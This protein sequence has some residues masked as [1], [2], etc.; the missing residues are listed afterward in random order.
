MA[1]SGKRG[2]GG[3]SSDF[4]GSLSGDD[5]LRCDGPSA[6]PDDVCHLGREA[7][8]ALLLHGSHVVVEKELQAV[9][10]GAVGIVL[11]QA[12]L[13]VEKLGDIAEHARGFDEKLLR[14]R[15]RWREVWLA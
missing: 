13:V 5:G 8:V 12:D 10:V 3:R 7:P 15:A 14:W 4:V 1:K 9:A 11:L 2:S 6:F